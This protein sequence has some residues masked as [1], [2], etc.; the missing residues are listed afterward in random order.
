VDNVLSCDDGTVCTKGDVC[1]GGKCAGQT[2][3]CDDGNPCTKDS[4]DAVKGCGYSAEADGTVCGSGGGGICASGTCSL[5][6]SLNPASSCQQILSTLPA[7][8]S[9]VY[10][11][12][13]TS[14]STKVV[15]QAYCDMVTQGGGWTLVVKA[16]GAKGTFGYAAGQWTSTA[17]FNPDFPA[18]DANEAKLAG[19]ANLAVK[20]VL[21]GAKVGTTTNYLVL[22]AVAT[23][24]HGL[25]SGGTYVATKAGRAAWK[26][27]MTGSSLQLN[28]NQEGFNT[29]VGGWMT[30]RMGIIANQENDCNSP[31]SF[32]GVGCAAGTSFTSGNY[33]SSSWSP[34]NGGVN[35][36]AFAYIFVR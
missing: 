10:F 16:D 1:A 4:C 25:V 31:D 15:Y 20:E 17:T 23:S 12:A 22:P 24:L 28:C 32:L 13:Y 6:S 30:C 34:D 3:S 9:G 5:G 19:Y 36:P 27:L 18:L 11:L 29:Q 8:K 33:A 35:F 14:G 7:S 2:V 26:G 21:I